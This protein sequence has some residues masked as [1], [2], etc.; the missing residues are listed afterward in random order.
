MLV[1][2]NYK[3]IYKEFLKLRY[4]INI[5]LITHCKYTNHIEIKLCFLV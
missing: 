1:N 4:K 2:I 3:T 5:S